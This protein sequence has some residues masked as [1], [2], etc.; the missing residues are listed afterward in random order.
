MGQKAFFSIF[1]TRFTQSFCNFSIRIAK[2]ESNFNPKAIGSAGA[3]GLFQFL[4]STFKRVEKLA[5]R[6]LNILDEKDSLDAA[7]ILM[8]TSGFHH[9]TCK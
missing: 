9:W 3:T 6:K 8:K 7:I 4:P 5:G 2:C 1:F